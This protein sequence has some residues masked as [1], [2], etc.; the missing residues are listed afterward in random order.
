MAAGTSPEAPSAAHLLHRAGQRA[1]ELFTQ[2]ARG[3]TP[4]QFEMLRAVSQVEGLSQTAIMAATG[5]DRSSTAA[6]VARLVQHGLLQR[7]RTKRDRRTYAVRI[8]D[9][10]RQVLEATRPVARAAEEELLAGLS[11]QAKADLLR[12]LDRIV[13]RK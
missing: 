5:I 7:R 11:A 13:S 2:A 10:G 4:R 1:D 9:K 12:T 6:L 3:L 8:T